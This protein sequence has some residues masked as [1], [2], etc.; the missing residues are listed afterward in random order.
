[1]KPFSPMLFGKYSWHYYLVLSTA[2][3]H[4]NVTCPTLT[5]ILL[6]GMQRASSEPTV[7]A[8]EHSFEPTISQPQI[9][10]L[11]AELWRPLINVLF[12]HYRRFINISRCL[13]GG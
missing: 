6:D 7:R 5:L 12:Q 13:G 4:I 8:A 1:M 11:P 3:L 2:G 10:S 9:R